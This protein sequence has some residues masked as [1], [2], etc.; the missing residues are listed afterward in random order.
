MQESLSG[1][2]L[3]IPIFAGITQFEVFQLTLHIISVE[4]NIIKNLIEG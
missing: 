3:E 4:S 2:I 1:A